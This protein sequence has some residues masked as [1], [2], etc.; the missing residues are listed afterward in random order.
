MVTRGKPFPEY[1]NDRLAATVDNSTTF[2]VVEGVNGRQF[3]Y[4]DLV[5]TLTSA[6]AALYALK[7][8]TT[9]TGNVVV[10]DA[11]ADGEAL[12]YDQASWRL[13]SGTIQST[14]P[15]LDMVDSNG[16][17]NNRM[18]RLQPVQENFRISPLND[19]IDNSIDSLIIEG[20]ADGG[21]VIVGS[22]SSLTIPAATAA[23]HAAQVSAIDA[24]TGRLAI[25]G[26]EIGDTGW[27]DI[28]SFIHAGV[29]HASNAGK[30][31]VKRNGDMVTLFTFNLW[32]AAGTGL[33]NLLDGT[34]GHLI[35]TGFQVSGQ[36]AF[37]LL[38]SFR[39][40]SGVEVSNFSIY[41]GAALAWV[42]ETI[43][44]SGTTTS[45]RPPISLM[46][47]VTYL[48]SDVWPASLPG[49]SYP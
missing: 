3:D 30:L 12:A 24:A 36:G 37:Q 22:G 18:F 14:T 40:N 20:F 1:V 4:D 31:L 15:A 25:G 39:S 21:G 33:V 28:T 32:L 13:G 7:S 9:F 6:L 46:G 11:N 16:V 29:L 23:T 43:L 41:S 44:T 27:R 49:I 8:G 42:S 34:P 38:H 2:P 35:P 47:Q 17:A 5:A 10:P 48:T 45:T 26:R 19:A